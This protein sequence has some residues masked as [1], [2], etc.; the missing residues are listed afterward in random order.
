[1]AD[2]KSRKK[3]EG[4]RRRPRTRD[5]VA[6]GVY[7]ASAATRLSLKN[8]ILMHVL[9]GGEDFDFDIYLPEARSILESLADEAEADAARAEQDQRAAKGRHSDS[10]GTHDYRSRDLKNLRRRQKQSMHVARELRARAA[11]ETQVVLLICDARD[12]AWDEVAANLG[13][14]LDTMSARP[15]LEPDYERMRAARMQSLRLVDLP[16]L[17]AHRRSLAAHHDLLDAGV[18]PEEVARQ[19]DGDDPT[20]GE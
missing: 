17:G 11:D 8:A 13:R 1:M 19:L 2:E 4:A 7:I 18:A 20:E 10:D 3:P 14:T 9:A 15:D 12:A 5:I 6:E 16:K